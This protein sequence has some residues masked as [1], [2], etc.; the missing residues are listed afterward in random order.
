MLLISTLDLDKYLIVHCR[1]IGAN[2]ETPMSS[3]TRKKP[4]SSLPIED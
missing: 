2:E 4:I 1:N 3:Q